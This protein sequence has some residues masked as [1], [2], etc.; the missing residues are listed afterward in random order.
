MRLPIALIPCVLAL[1]ASGCG[2]GSPATGITSGCSAETFRPNYA[3]QAGTLRTWGA[4]PVKIYFANT[5][6]YG[7]GSSFDP[8]VRQGFDQWEIES[9]GVF[10]LQYVSTEGE[11]DIVV[12]YNLLS[13]PPVSGDELGSTT[14]SFTTGGRLTHADI[15][16]NVW[17]G[18][19]AQDRADFVGTAA[20]EMGHGLGIGG[21]SSSTAD[22][23][24]FASSVNNVTPRDLNTMKTA[25]CSL[26]VS[27]AKVRSQP[28]GP[29]YTETTVCPRP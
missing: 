13:S 17:N 25:Y 29:I 6:T 14:V 9:G 16:L 4:F 3:A 5:A 26:F 24:Y 12:R 27:S 20:H 18:M 1:I 8:L 19:T 21:H 11:A 10:D 7:S 15:K 28:L 22:L 2:T 23:M